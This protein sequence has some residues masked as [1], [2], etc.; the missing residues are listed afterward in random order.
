M[1]KN[2]SKNMVFFFPLASDDKWQC[3]VNF[4]VQKLSWPSR[5]YCESNIN[6][7]FKRKI[8]PC[9]PK[10]IRGGR[11][12]LLLAKTLSS[13]LGTIIEWGQEVREPVLYFDGTPKAMIR[14]VSTI[15]LKKIIVIQRGTKLFQNSD[16]SLKTILWIW[17]PWRA[18]LLLSKNSGLNFRNIFLPSGK[19]ILAG[20]NGDSIFLKFCCSMGQNQIRNGPVTLKTD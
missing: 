16:S 1:M 17:S 15:T 7:T 4:Q 13:F 10:D 14:S 6:R 9:C 19:V 11:G 3:D 18:H 5:D 12:I 8:H 20:M 2:F